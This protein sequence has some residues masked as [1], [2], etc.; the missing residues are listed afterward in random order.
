LFWSPLSFCLSGF[1]NKLIFMC[2]LD[3]L[4]ECNRQQQQKALNTEH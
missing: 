2:A 3:A 4:L 1:P